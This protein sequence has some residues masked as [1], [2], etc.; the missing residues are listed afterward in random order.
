MA[1][2]TNCA[3][4]TP[5]AV[6]PSPHTPDSLPLIDD[7]SDEIEAVQELSNVSKTDTL[8]V[9]PLLYS[10]SIGGNDPGIKFSNASNKLLISN[11]SAVNSSSSKIKTNDS[12]TL[13]KFRA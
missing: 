13:T 7:V 1:V 3:K 2:V 8:T 10:R 4:G 6:F 5:S 9:S 12:V 11:A